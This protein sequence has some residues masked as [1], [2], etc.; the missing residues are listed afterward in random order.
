M[1]A[2]QERFDTWR[3]E[4]N[5]ERPHDALGGEV[6]ASQYTPSPRLMPTRLPEPEYPGHFEVRYLSKSGNIKWKRQQLFVSQALAHE[7]VGLEEVADGVWSLYFYD[8]L[9]ARLD[10]RSGLKLHA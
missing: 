9:L 8:R 4:F 7:Y 5:H 2:Q 6:P 10:E 3:P 1:I